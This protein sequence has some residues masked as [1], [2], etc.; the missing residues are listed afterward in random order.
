MSPALENSTGAGSI[1]HEQI[2]LSSAFK[3][4]IWPAEGPFQPEEPSIVCSP[5][6][7]L[8]RVAAVCVDSDNSRKTRSRS[9]WMCAMRL[10]CRSSSRWLARARC[11]ISAR[12]RSRSVARRS[13]TRRSSDRR[14]APL[15]FDEGSTFRFF[16]IVFCLPGFGVRTVDRFAA[17]PFDVAAVAVREVPGHDRYQSTR[18]AGTRRAKSPSNLDRMLDR[19]TI[20][21]GNAVLSV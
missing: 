11:S 19:S 21:N 18:D 9:A 15:P 14:C 3:S 2:Q 8:V 1:C 20:E 12:R 6:A 5:Y 4:A 16:F 10:N 7:I 17:L 13:P